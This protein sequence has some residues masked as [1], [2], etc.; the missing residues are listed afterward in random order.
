MIWY[1]KKQKSVPI[2]AG[3]IPVV[4]EILYTITNLFFLKKKKK[5]ISFKKPHYVNIFKTKIKFPLIYKHNLCDLRQTLNDPS[6]Q[7]QL[8]EAWWLQPGRD[9]HLVNQSKGKVGISYAEYTYRSS[10]Q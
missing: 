2:N 6:P 3:I 4:Y 9:L 8:P 1:L 5:N 7:I 10:L